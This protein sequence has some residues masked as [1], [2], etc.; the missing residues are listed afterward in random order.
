MRPRTKAPMTEPMI[1]P[2]PPVSSVPPIT[3]AAIAS[4]SQPMPVMFWALPSREVYTTPPMAAS[5]PLITYTDSFVRRTGN[6][7][8][9]ADG[10][11]PPIV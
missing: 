2:D 6:P 3:T 7:M 1:E 11:D 4:S 5:V 9:L 8:R 10:S